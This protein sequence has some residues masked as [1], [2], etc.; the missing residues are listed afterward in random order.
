[1]HKPTEK[2]AVTQEMIEAGAAVIAGGDDLDIGPTGAE[3]LAEVVLKGDLTA[4]VR[5]TVNGLLAV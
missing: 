2:I 5:M 1:M 3:I 4:F